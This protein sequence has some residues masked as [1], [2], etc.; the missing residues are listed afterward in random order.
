MIKISFIK[1]RLF[2]YFFV[3]LILISV[4]FLYVK[5][6]QYRLSP[7]LEFNEKLLP[8][9]SSSLSIALIGDSWVAG[10]DLDS[11]LLAKLNIPSKRVQVTSSGQ[12]GAHSKDI[13]LNVFKNE[14][15]INSLHNII[16]SNPDYCF[17][18]SGNNDLNMG[19]EYYTHHMILLIQFL[20]EKRIRPVVMLV[21]DYE[22]HNP[23]FG[24]LKKIKI[25]FKNIFSNGEYIDSANLLNESLI[26]ELK[27]LNIYCKVLLISKS[28]KRGMLDYVDYRELSFKTFHLNNLGKQFLTDEIVK[29]ISIDY[30][31]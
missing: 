4:F 10:N 23:N 29:I 25:Y 5:T 19:V 28:Y 1:F 24:V 21:P 17:I 9:D 13:Y 20:L 12:Y 31:N 26:N 27:R 22:Y 8:R 2:T 7:R 14:F 11:F 30:N 16:L 6:E 18:S 15:E 3:L